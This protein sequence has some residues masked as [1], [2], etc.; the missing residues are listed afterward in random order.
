MRKTGK[1]PDKLHLILIPEARR[2]WWKRWRKR[3]RKFRVTQPFRYVT[4][5]GFTLAVPRG[6]TINGASIPCF[7]YRLIGPP[8][9]DYFEASA[10]HDWLWS[11]AVHGLKNGW[12]ADFRWANA[13]F[14]DAMRTLGVARW[15]RG[16]MWAAVSAN[17][18][19]QV[20]KYSRQ[21]AK[22]G[23]KRRSR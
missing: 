20:W 13:V 16:L 7:C 17:G 2:P 3:R 19:F 18:R 14:L 11:V 23:R 5:E 21:A 15:R 9:G 10:V 6:T 8:C 1:F 12:P 4:S 22:A